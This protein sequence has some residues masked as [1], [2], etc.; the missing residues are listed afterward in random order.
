MA[1][2]LDYLQWR[3]DLG[4]DV[5]P[6]N[7]IDALLFARLA[8]MPW[9]NIV[10]ERFDASAPLGE[11]ALAVLAADRAGSV[12][13]ALEKEDV[14]L[15]TLTTESARLR[16]LGLTGFVNVFDPLRQEQFAAVTALLPDGGALIAF[17]GTDGTLVGWKED[18]NMAFSATVPAQEEAVRY[19]REAAQSARGALVLC[20]HSKGGNLAVYAGAFCPEEIQ[21]RIVAVRNFDGPGFG[22]ETIESPGFARI[23]PRARTYLPESSVVGMLLEHEEDFTIVDSRS[24]GIFQHN[25]FLWEIV[26]DGFVTVESRTNSSFLID[27]TLKE[28]VK[29]M[30]P[31]DR[32]RLINGLYG[33]LSATKGATVR[34]VMGGRH[35]ISALRAIGDMDE[36]TRKLMFSALR[37]LKS[38]L[39]I[40]LPAFFDN[41][42]VAETLERIP[43]ALTGKLQE[44]E[45]FR[46][47]FPEDKA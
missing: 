12:V 3:G 10:P 26:R 37:I 25:T 5:K 4:L 7:D 45:L 27:R 43:N 39:K 41:L 22:R 13:P 38:S 11:A 28:W 29:A 44:I 31:A 1:N 24:L 23:L 32:E 42:R 21:A 16:D 33:A 34:D 18:F 30:S 17:R 46:R 8:Y 20:G 36:E 35:T 19:V 47:F 40:T 14:Q 15:L 2:M 9:D 6:M